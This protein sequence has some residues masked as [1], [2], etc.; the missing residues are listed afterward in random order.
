MCFSPDPHGQGNIQDARGYFSY[1]GYAVLCLCR[2]YPPLW[3]QFLWSGC[4]RTSVFIEWSSHG[5]DFYLR[6][7]WSE[8][9]LCFIDKCLNVLFPI[10]WVFQLLWVSLVGKEKKGR[11][12]FAFVGLGKGTLADDTWGWLHPF[13]CFGASLKLMGIHLEVFVTL[14][15]WL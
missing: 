5:N 3:W 4:L 13:Q 10:T 7:S 14:L 6:L 12:Y 8:F 2:S 15:V 11:L 9:D 1:P